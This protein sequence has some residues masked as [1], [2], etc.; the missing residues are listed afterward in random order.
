MPYDILVLGATGRCPALEPVVAHSSRLLSGYTGRLI[1]RYLYAHQQYRTSFTL[2]IAGRSQAK[3]DALIKEEKL[4]DSV[5]VLTVDVLKP[6]E[7]D[8]AVKDAKVV[9]NT[10]GPFAKWGTPVVRCVVLCIPCV[11]LL[12]GTSIG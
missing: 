9:I 11:Q 2:A 4:D 7:I 6:N 1:V 3:L 10:V 8:R 12:T 5:Q